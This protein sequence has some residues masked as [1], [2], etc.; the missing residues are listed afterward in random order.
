MEPA[1]VLLTGL[2]PADD[3]KG[4]ILRLF[5]ASG[6]TE[7]ASLHWAEPGNR[8]VWFSDTSERPLRP[9]EG[10]IEVP[11]WGVVT[12]RVALAGSGR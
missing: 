3:G 1:G 8:Q 5:G 6:R 12:L 4:L 11:G 9:A 2:K 7:K 10:P